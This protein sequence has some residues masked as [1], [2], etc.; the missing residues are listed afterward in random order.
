MQVSLELQLK[1][2]EAL[3]L[4]LWGLRNNNSLHLHPPEEEEED[5]DKGWNEREAGGQTRAFYC[6]YPGPMSS[7]SVTPGV[8]LLWLF[9]QTA[10]RGAARSQPLLAEKG[11]CQGGKFGGRRTKKYLLIGFHLRQI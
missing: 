4:T 11:G 8:C 10:L 3:N 6:C 7:A 2:A 1:D 9:N 5:K